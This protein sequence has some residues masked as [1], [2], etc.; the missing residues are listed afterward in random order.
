MIGHDLLCRKALSAQLRG[1]TL[2]EIAE[3]SKVTPTTIARRIAKAMDMDYVKQ[4]RDRLV[5]LVDD[6]VDVF[7]TEVRIKKNWK[8]ADKVLS[9]TGV[10]VQNVDMRFQGNITV[11]LGAPGKP[12]VPAEATTRDGKRVQ[13]QRVK[14]LG[15]H[16]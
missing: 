16:E 11:E 3:K 10:L 13:K 2:T 1:Q 7:E 5:T 4:G 15:A 14:E 9:G 8:V 6:S 12:A